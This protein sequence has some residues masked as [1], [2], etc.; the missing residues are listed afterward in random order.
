MVH[1]KA[2]VVNDEPDWAIASL[3]L[4]ILI[5]LY[6]AAAYVVRAMNIV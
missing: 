4:I 1:A 2:E 3:A 6:M 5:A